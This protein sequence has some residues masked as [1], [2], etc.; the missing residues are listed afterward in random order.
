MG[1]PRVTDGAMNSEMFDLHVTT[2][3]VPTLRKGDVVI[4]DN[5]SS[6]KSSGAAQALRVTDGAMNSEMFDLHVTTQPVPTLRK[7]D[8]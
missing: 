4:L 2:Q 8:V 6:H 3:P 1:A 7:G 5:L